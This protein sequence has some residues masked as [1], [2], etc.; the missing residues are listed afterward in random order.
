MQAAVTARLE[1]QG[2]PGLWTIYGKQPTNSISFELIWNPM[3]P[4]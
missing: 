2:Q 1:F 4:V 3:Y